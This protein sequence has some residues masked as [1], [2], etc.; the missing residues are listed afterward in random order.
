MGLKLQSQ[1]SENFAEIYPAIMVLF[2]FQAKYDQARRKWRLVPVKSEVEIGGLNG[3]S[4]HLSSSTNGIRAV[5]SS[6]LLDSHTDTSPMTIVMTQQDGGIAIT[7]PSN[8]SNGHVANGHVA[9]GHALN[10][11]TSA[12][13]NGDVSQN[14]SH[15]ATDNGGRTTHRQ[16]THVIDL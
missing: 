2:Y 9:N 8:M 1:Q 11:Y 3:A 14:N 12:S 4:K 10:G 15:N 16:G 7:M 13:R 5:H 6:L